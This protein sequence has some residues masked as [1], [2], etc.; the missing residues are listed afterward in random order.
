M[1]QDSK[2]MRGERS[3]VFTNLREGQG[4]DE[5]ASFIVRE[6]M[7]SGAWRLLSTQ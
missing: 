4:V 1:E 3:F 5:V 7:L 2:R 6:G